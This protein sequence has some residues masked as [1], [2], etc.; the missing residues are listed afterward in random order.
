MT[1]V[2]VHGPETRLGFACIIAAMPVQWI[3]HKGKRLLL[4]DASNL[5]N[6]HAALTDLLQSLVTLLKKEPKDSVRAIA[7]L[8]K[9]HLSNNALMILMRHAPLAAP[10]FQK[11]ALV[12]EAN[13]NARNIVLDSFK[14]VIKVLPTRFVDL[15]EAKDWLVLE[16]PQPATSN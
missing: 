9:T 5:G 3:E 15:E 4:I 1:L 8:R 14:V 13:N 6:D 12:I 7:D 16:T 2:L 11:S 10:Y